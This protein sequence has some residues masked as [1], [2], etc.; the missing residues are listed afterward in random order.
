MQVM[1]E[2]CEGGIYIFIFSMMFG[3]TYVIN[4]CWNGNTT[5]E[6]P[7]VGGFPFI[8]KPCTL[9]VDSQ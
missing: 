6:V 4:Q 9:V 3:S 8:L 2:T 5:C 1:H 7:F